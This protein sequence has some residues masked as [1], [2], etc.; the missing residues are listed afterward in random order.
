MP[1]FVIPPKPPRDAKAFER[2]LQCIFVLAAD[3]LGLPLVAQGAAKLPYGDFG[4]LLMYLNEGG[5][6]FG[7]E[8]E[9]VTKLLA[10]AE[11]N[12]L[13]RVIVEGLDTLSHNTNNG[14]WTIFKNCPNCDGRC[15][16]WTDFV[17]PDWCQLRRA[18]HALVPLVR[19]VRLTG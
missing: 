19:E 11:N 13:L 12:E 3:G 6:L 1:K 7:S 8:G 2:S 5:E 14:E 4:V 9:E 17:R 15:K 18:F 16:C 10:A